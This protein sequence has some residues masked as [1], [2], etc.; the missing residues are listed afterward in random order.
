MPEILD[1]NQT[2]AT[3]TEPVL[4][5]GA[6]AAMVKLNDGRTAGHTVEV[7]LGAS[8]TVEEREFLQAM[9]RYTRERRRPFPTWV[10]VLAVVR[11]LG[12]RKDS[13]PGGLP[14]KPV[15]F[16][17]PKRGKKKAS[18]PSRGT[19]PTDSQL[20]ASSESGLDR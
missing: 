13:P 20:S 9:E 2:V 16:N 18:R 7:N 19:K 3:Q 11:S 8:Y 14:C 5:R 10:E 17:R 12:Y 4:R 6:A 1:Q 15:V